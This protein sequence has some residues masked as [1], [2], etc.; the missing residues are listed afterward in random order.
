M[1]NIINEQQK[2]NK[3]LLN[4]I[5]TL[6]KQLENKEDDFK[7]RIWNAINNVKENES[8]EIA[9]TLMTL[10]Q[11]FWPKDGWV[12]I[13]K[14]SGVKKAVFG[15]EFTFENIIKGFTEWTLL[16]CNSLSYVSEQNKKLEEKNAELEKSNQ[17]YKEKN[18][19]VRSQTRRIRNKS[20]RVG[21]KSRNWS[22]N[23]LESTRQVQRMTW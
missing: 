11:H 21:R 15:N 22:W 23:E 6:K 12:K 7:L 1:T 16:S 3:E 20:R 2:E 4:E 19:T 9:G 10:E 5:K 17:E 13:Q 18:S 8:P 14:E